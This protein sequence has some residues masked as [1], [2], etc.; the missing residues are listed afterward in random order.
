MNTSLIILNVI[1]Y[2]YQLFDLSDPAL[3]QMQREYGAVPAR[4]LSGEGLYTVFTAM[5]LHGGFFHLGGNMLYLYIFGD[6]VED[7]LGHV[8]YLIFYLACGLGATAGHIVVDPSSTIPMIGASGAVSGVLGAYAMRFPRARVTILVPIFF[9]LTTFRVP[10]ITV[11]G[12]W[13]LIQ[14]G[15]GVLALGS[16]ISGGIAWFAHIGG[17]LLGIFLSRMFKDTRRYYYQEDDDGFA[18]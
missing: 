4:I 3:M 2:L 5:F 10:A 14:V 17:F 9:I 8:N 7:T 13:F 12:I 16:Q 11:L 6:N 1:V 15:N 18:V